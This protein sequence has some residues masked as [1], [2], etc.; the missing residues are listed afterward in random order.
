MFGNPFKKELRRQVEI[1]DA[2][3]NEILSISHQL[4]RAMGLGYSD[5]KEALDNGVYWQ[6]NDCYISARSNDSFCNRVLLTVSPGIGMYNTFLRWEGTV[7]G[8]RNSDH[9]YIPSKEKLKEIFA[10]IPNYKFNYIVE[11]IS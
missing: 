10:Q 1:V 7:P 8:W 3:K 11:S 5:M 6:L 2:D 9:G 4:Q